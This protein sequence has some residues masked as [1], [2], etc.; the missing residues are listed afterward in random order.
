[1]VV[2]SFKG[3]A[4]ALLKLREQV[5]HM[6]PNRSRVDDCMVGDLSHQSRISDHNP[7]RF[8][9]VTALDLT[10]DPRHGFDSYAFADYLKDT[11]DPRIKYVI[12]NRRIWNTSDGW[13]RYIGLNPHDHHVHIS[14]KGQ[15]KYYNDDSDWDLSEFQ[16][17][18]QPDAPTADLPH[19]ILYVGSKG[20]DVRYLQRL[21]GIEQDGDFGKQTQR[22]VLDFQRRNGLVRDGVVGRQTWTKLLTREAT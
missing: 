4:P 19:P 6:F 8:G 10:H 3:N 22:A 5:N 16:S 9:I 15:Q 7:N 17:G 13:R 12:S 20:N 11:A 21:L 1:V 14:V 2:T 18:E